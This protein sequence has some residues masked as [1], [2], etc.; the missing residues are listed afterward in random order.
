MTEFHPPLDFSPITERDFDLPENNN[1]AIWF[2]INIEYDRYD[3]PVSTPVY[4]GTT[5][6]QPDVFNYSWRNYGLRV[7]F[8]RLADLFTDLDIHPTIALNAEICDHCPQIIDEITTNKWPIMGHGLTNSIRLAGKD[9]DE[10]RAIIR[11][12]KNTI[13]THTNTPI[14]GWLGPGLTETFNTLD[15]LAEEE[16]EYVAD[17][18]NDDQ[19]YSFNTTPKPILSIPYAVDLNDVAVFTAFR[20][21]AK[22]YHDALLDQ[23]TH[24]YTEGREPGN[25]KIMAVPIHPYLLGQP[26]R[27]TYFKQAIEKFTRH[28]N[29]WFTTGDELSTYYHDEYL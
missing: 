20:Y 8:W 5:N 1:L 27:F 6:Y 21:T 3:M 28:P 17:W 2:I 12:T 13:E 23:F 29:V 7:G 11:E 24:L 15:I 9:E 26:H 10:E 16:F 19:P 18:S 22:D 4:G 14:S 25:A